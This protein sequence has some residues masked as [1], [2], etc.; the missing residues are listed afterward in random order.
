MLSRRVENPHGGA[1]P[2][3]SAVRDNRAIPASCT[4][5]Y[6]ILIGDLRKGQGRCQVELELLQVP[7]CANSEKCAHADAQV[8]CG[9]SQRIALADPLDAA[10]PGASRADVKMFVRR[11]R[12]TT[13][14]V[15]CRVSL[16]F[17]LSFQQACVSVSGG[18]GSLNSPVLENLGGRG[19]D[20]EAP[21]PRATGRLRRRRASRRRRGVDVGVILVSLIHTCKLCGA[22]RF[23]YLTELQRHAEEVALAPS[24]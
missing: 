14:C 4:A 10:K 12:F 22:N 13:F 20:D 19:D 7:R 16:S 15:T 21:R 2:R 23:D 9:R 18:V 17:V 8:V 5:T 1:L 6:K 11:R 24:Q 3:P